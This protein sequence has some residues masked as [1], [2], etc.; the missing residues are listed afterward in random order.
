MFTIE[1]DPQSA[2]RVNAKSLWTEKAKRYFKYKSDIKLLCASK[3]FKKLN[4]ELKITFFIPM[5]NSWS[6]KKKEE[7][8]LQ[9]HQQKPDIDNLSKAFMDAFGED[10]SHV[11]KLEAEKYWND[12]GKIVIHEL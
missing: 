1:I 12:K 7:M 11:Y 8:L 2:P 6:K 5:P 4:S 9:P 10:D 3:G